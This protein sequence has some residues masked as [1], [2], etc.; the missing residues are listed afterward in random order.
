MNSGLVFDIKRF[1]IHDGPGIRTT[2]FLKGCPLRCWWCHNP[3]S[4]L[5]QPEILFNFNNCIQCYQCI[6]QCPQ[7]AITIKDKYP[8][9]DKNKCLACGYCVNICPAIARE[10]SG[11][12]FNVGQVIAEIRKDLIF[13]QESG[14][15]VTFSGGEPMVQI[16]F[17]EQLLS[18]CKKMEISTVIDTCG[19]VPWVYFERIV[20]MVDLWLYDIKVIDEKTHKKYTGVQNN[21]I[22]DN[23]RRLSK[24]TSHIEIRVPVIPK[25][26]DSC[27]DIRAIA[28]LMNSLRL[29]KVSLLPFH[30]MGIEKFA[31]LQIKN[32][33]KNISTNKNEHIT[34]LQQIFFQ[35]NIYAIIGG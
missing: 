12:K 31:R 16:H 24:K 21:L 11:S 18:E 30:R 19:H 22:I 29:E 33:L 28:E 3:E 17:L 5:N 27:K 9:T 20:D 2:V 10:I 4:W 15:G 1:A 32:R 8:Y 7:N 14:G 35:N 23:L 13:Y 25:I 6:S 34:K 26:N